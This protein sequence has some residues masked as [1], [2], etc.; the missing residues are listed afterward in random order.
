MK[1]GRTKPVQVL[2]LAASMIMALI[3]AAAFGQETRGTITGR[4][5]DSGG[6]IVAGAAVKVTNVAM[7]TTVSVTSNDAGV[8][9]APYLVP[10]TYQITVEFQGFKKYVREKVGLSIGE[11]LDLPIV[12]EAGGTEESITVTADSA[13]LDT[14]TASMGQTVDNRRVAELPLVHG[15]PYTMIGLSPGVTF[16]RDQRLDRPFEPTH[17][18]GFTIDGTRAN[19]SDLTIDGAPSTATANPSEVIATYVPPTD[20]IQEFKV[21]TAT[22]DSQFGNTEGGV[23]SISIKSGTNNL[24]GTAYLWKEPGNLAANDFFGNLRGQP[25][26]ESYSNR[27]GGSVSGPIVLPKLYHG[28]DKTFFLFGFEGIRDSRPRYDSTTPTVPT[29]AMKNGDFSAFLKLGP[30]YQLYNPFT[31][32]ADPAR[33]GHFIEDPFVGNIIPTNLISPISTALLKYWGNPKSPGTPEFL[34]NNAD[35]TLAERTKR[36]DNYTIRLDHEISDRQRIFGRA[37]WYDRDSAYNDYFGTIATGQ[38]FAFNSRQAVIDDVYTFNSTTVLNLRYGYNRFIRFGD[39]KPEGYGFDLTTVG[40]PSAYND[41]IDPSIRRFPR[42]DFPAGSYQGTG[43][44]GETRPIDSHSFGVTLNKAY[45]THSAKAGVEFRSYREND[46]FTNNN[47]TGQF[48]FDSTYVKQKDDSSSSQVVPQSFAAFLLGVPTSASNVTRAASYAEQSTTWGFFVQ[49]DWKVTQKLTLNLGLRYEYETPLTE[50]YNRSVSGFDFSYIQPVQAAARAKYATINDPALKADVPVLNVTG[51]LIF[52]GINGQPDGLYTTPKNSF[53]PRFGFAY[54]IN[55]KTVVRGGYGIFFGFLGER[56]SDVIQTGYSIATNFV[57][58]VDNIHVS[59]WSN[60]FP[61]GIK[62]PV[63]AAQ[64]FQT[65]IGN[66]ISFFN[67]NPL[68]P[69]NQRWQLSLQR[70]LPGGI[71]I[72]ASYVGNRGTHIEITRDINAV[73]NQFLSTLPTRDAT[74]ISYLTGSVPNPFSGQGIPGVGSTSTISRQ[75][76]MRPF[77]EFGTINTTTNDGISWYHAGQLRI[78]KRFSR[79]YT[80]QAS[81]THSKFMQATEYL[82]PGDPAPTR[83]IS[84]Q[85]YPNRFAL[86][87]IFELPFGKGQRFLADS[88]GV[89]NRIVGGWQV[90]GV[91][92]YQTGAPL[93]WGNYIY[94]GDFRNIAIPSDQQSLG[95]WFNNSGFVALRTATG[96]VVQSNGQ[97]VWVDFNDPCKSSYNATTCPGTPLASPTGFNRDSAFQLANNI[98]TFPLRF[99]YLRVQPTNNVD[100]SVMKNTRIKESMSVQFRAEFTNFFNHPWLSAASGAS[101]TSGVIT[102]PTNADFGKIANLSNQGNYARRVQ[103]GIKFIF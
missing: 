92:A 62:E 84:D 94:N 66:S 67:Q 16:A 98:R 100:F 20:I 31:R 29:D 65:N 4:V 102:A 34:N 88:N 85:D 72:E 51:G 52:P 37:S 79:G 15:D 83:T 77:P 103:L 3:P 97:P 33:P 24:H 26:P 90:Q 89:V 14:S 68:T 63:G 95:Q 57:P 43:Q 53:M 71:V 44:G 47:Q 73:P 74:R 81:Y 23:T 1:L 27:F 28:R 6:A 56:R 80:V 21:Q 87:S 35:S 49:D 36:Y 96:T 40:F 8:F 39:M 46:S 99:S 13:R 30:Q 70:E 19:R 64:G 61:S 50:R 54:Q 17:I 2:I 25:R 41:A 12:L 42:I 60:P 45:G 7:G 91:Y 9:V 38:V 22:F 11:S 10:G 86:S 82:N 76:L 101:G 78:E 5:V 93:T 59:T 48:V 75:N 58:T 32:R 69:Y 55:G 18:V